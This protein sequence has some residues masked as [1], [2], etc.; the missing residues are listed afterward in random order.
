M[1]RR[2]EAN[3]DEYEF[4]GENA[5]VHVPTNARFTAYEGQG[6][7]SNYLRGELGNVLSNGDDYEEETVVRIANKLLAARPAASV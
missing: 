3:E 2:K 6:H 1:P 4:E 5:V 7:W